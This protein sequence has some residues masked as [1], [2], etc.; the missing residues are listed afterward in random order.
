MVDAPPLTKLQSPRWTSDCCDGSQNLKSVVLSLLGSMET[1][2]GASSRQPAAAGRSDLGSETPDLRAQRRLNR[3]TCAAPAGPL[4]DGQVPELGLQLRRARPSWVSRAPT[5]PPL[6]PSHPNSHPRHLWGSSTKPCP[7][8]CKRVRPPSQSP[9]QPSARKPSWVYPVTP[10]NTGRSSPA[11]LPFILPLPPHTHTHSHTHTRTQTAHSTFQTPTSYILP[12]PKQTFTHSPSVASFRPPPRLPGSPS[13]RSRPAQWDAGTPARR[14][15]RA[16]RTD[17]GP[18]RRETNKGGREPGAQEPRAAA[19]GPGSLGRAGRGLLRSQEAAAA[20]DADLWQSAP[21]G[22]CRH[23]GLLHRTLLAHLP[24]RAAV[25]ECPA[26][27]CP[28]TGPCSRTGFSGSLCGSAAPGKGLKGEQGAPPGS[29]PPRCPAGLALLSS[30][31]HSLGRPCPAGGRG[32]T[33]GPARWGSP[34]SRQASPRG[35]GVAVQAP[36]E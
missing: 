7:F 29:Q 17:L 19:A 25:G 35:P 2:A 6:T 3:L 14:S 16:R 1:P 33:P 32:L 24:L 11:A 34:R 12:S 9:A 23:H 20:E 21:L 13:P 36:G 15:G 22:R 28:R 27:P 8:R 26:R 10:V 18:P 4:A 30:R 31:G 5:L